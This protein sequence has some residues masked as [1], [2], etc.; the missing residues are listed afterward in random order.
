M[1]DP[2]IVTYCSASAHPSPLP[3][4]SS[5]DG[6]APAQPSLQA[7]TGA[8]P[9]PA[10]SEGSSAAGKTHP[11]APEGSHSN[12]LSP[13]CPS[14]IS[15]SNTQHVQASQA[16]QDPSALQPRPS[17]IPNDKKLPKAIENI[18]AQL[19]SI[20]PNYSSSD[21]TGFIRDT[22]RRNGNTL[23]GL[24][25]EEILRRVT[26]LILDQRLKAPPPAGRAVHSLDS[27][28]PAA[29]RSRE[30]PAEGIAPGSP[31]AAPAPK[32]SSTKNPPQP[33]LQ[34]WG[35][36]GAIPKAKWK[37]QDNAVSF[38]LFLWSCCFVQDAK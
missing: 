9:A 35:N 21:L 27:A 3:A 18:I 22:Q 19:Q 6:K 29:A 10:T 25:P 38:P 31:R 36:A 30:G 7:Q 4:F 28:P 13:S 14:G 37:K 33:N 20:F 16:H 15:G 12:K 17:G 5:S 2:A 11:K 24:S 34:P 26:E 8:K 23:A 32:N 1:C